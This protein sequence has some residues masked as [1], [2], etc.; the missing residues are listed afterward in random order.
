MAKTSISIT[1]Q[2][3]DWIHEAVSSG[4][5]SS[6]SEVIRDALRDWRAKQD[7]RRLWDEGVSSGPSE[8]WDAEEIKKEGRKRAAARKA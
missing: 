5:Y 1:D 2:Q 6:T 4:E 7:L 8:P 3:A